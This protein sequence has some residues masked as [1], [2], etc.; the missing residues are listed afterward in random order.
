[1]HRMPENTYNTGTCAKCLS[2]EAAPTP[3]VVTIPHGDQL[4]TNPTDSG[5][6]NEEDIIIIIV[7]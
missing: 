1:M 5:Q 6:N 4:D 7:I 2:S 3:T